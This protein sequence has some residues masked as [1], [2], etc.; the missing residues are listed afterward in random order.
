MG[1][2][3]R[4]A[5]MMELMGERVRVHWHLREKKWSVSTKGPNGWR[6]VRD[7]NGKQVLYTK[8]VLRNVQF[9]VNQGGR[10]RTIRERRKN[11]HAWMVGT[12]VDWSL[13]DD[14]ARVPCGIPVK[15]NPYYLPSF[16]YRREDNTDALGTPVYDAEF[17]AAG[18]SNGVLV[19]EW[20]L[21]KTRYTRLEL[22]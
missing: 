4:E 5:E 19:P 3:H 7:D 6:V 15:Y 14:E 22:A 20:G 1:A 12:L 16:Y 10:E 2:V 18:S 9:K 17:A 13:T 21:N 11:V 8:V